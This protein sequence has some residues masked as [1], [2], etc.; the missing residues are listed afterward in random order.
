MWEHRLIW[1]ATPPS[2]WDSAWTTALDAVRQH[3]RQPE[4][5]P[6]TYLVLSDR[7][8]IGLKLRGQSGEFEVKV[9]H[10]AREGWELWEK[11]PFFAWNDLEAA[12]FAA[13]LRQQFPAGMIDPK[14]P[15]V[16]GAK[17]LLQRAGISLR[18]IVIEKLRAQARAGDL[19]PSFVSAGVDP[20]W[21]AE[22]VVI[23]GAG[24]TARSICF[25]AM[26]PKA[27]LSPVLFGLAINIGYP[28]FIIRESLP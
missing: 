19:L 26:T 13:L 2:W 7:P 5:R 16:E 1:T 8:D 14:A 22:I 20:A 28:E 15:A 4:D 12:R 11:T 10:D 27:G 18:E 9:R 23:K 3:R 6:D 25:E 21:L 17:A 24:P